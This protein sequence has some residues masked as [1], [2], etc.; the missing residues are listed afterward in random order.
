M[1][2]LDTN[3]VSELFKREPDERVALWAAQLRPID[4][5]ISVVTVFEIRRGFELLVEGRRKRSLETLLAEFT[6]DVGT[7]FSFN[8]ETAAAAARYAAERSRMGRPVVDLADLMIAGTVLTAPDMFDDEI[9][10]ATRNVDDFL[11][12]D[13]VN[14]WDAG[15]PS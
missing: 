4:M 10:L 5:A 13:V 6:R 15:Q 14:P 8:A 3:V 11:G 7:L 1:I 9:T 12:L 2:I